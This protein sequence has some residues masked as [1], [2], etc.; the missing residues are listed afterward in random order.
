MPTPDFGATAQFFKTLAD[1]TRLQLLYLVAG[2]NQTALHSAQLS[3]AT[4]VS[5]PTVTHHMQ[6]LQAAGLVTRRQTGRHAYYTVV[7]EVFGM[8]NSFVTTIQRQTFASEV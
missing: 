2:A 7:P 4:G 1:P 3:E 6:R 8:V 5:N